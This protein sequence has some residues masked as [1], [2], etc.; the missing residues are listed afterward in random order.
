[1]KVCV[2]GGRVYDPTNRRAGD[3]ADIA[4]DGDRIVSSDGFEPERVIDATGGIVMAGGVD[5]HS[6]IAGPMV[7]RARRLLAETSPGARA[8]PPL[9]PSS[10]LTGRLYAALGYTTAIDAAVAPTGARQ[11]YREIAATDHLDCGFLLLLANHEGLIDRLARGERTAAVEMARSLLVRTGAFGIKAVNPGGVARWKH[12]ADPVTTLDD[13]IGSTD[14]TPGHILELLADVA[15]ES[16]LP[17]PLHIHCNRLG[18]PMNIETTLATSVRLAGR[19]HHLAHVQFHAYGASSSGALA[20]AA[21]RLAEYLNQTPT[22]TVDIGQVMLDE[23][24][25]L[26]A[27]EALE[28]RLWRLTG[29]RYVNHDVEL[30]TGCGMV[31]FRYLPRSRLHAL[32]WAVGLELLLLVRDPWQ[33]ALTTDH[34]NGGSFLKYPKLIAQLMSR[35]VR[36]EAMLQ[37]NADAIAGTNLPDLSR[38]YSLAEI[39]VVTRAGPARILGLERKGHLGVGADADVVVY[40]DLSDR[41]KMF[42]TPRYV[43]RSGRV[44]AENG[45]PITRGTGRVLRAVIGDDGVDEAPLRRWFDAYGSYPLDQLGPRRPELEAARAI[46]P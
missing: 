35:D 29:K 2:R 14:V 32:Q 9:V 15:E 28:H 39:A 16:R 3:V 11:C 40:D 21:S 43:L 4:I 27:D 34:P 42:R 36:R 46:A 18:T 6:H 25:T 33:I 24:L 8:A 10:S 19:R 31:E 5:M 41:E 13:R 30:E 7:N 38:E 37:A 20:S 22:V 1:M 44:I 17:H 26:S 12:G 23:A 45:E